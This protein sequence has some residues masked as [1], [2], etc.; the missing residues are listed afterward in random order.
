MPKYYSQ[1]GEDALLDQIFGNQEQ[2]IFIE[3]GCID[4]RRFSNTLTFEERG[5]KGI[6]VEA[7]SG[8][9]DMLKKNRPNSIVC[10][11][12][13][14]ESDE[15]TVFYANA[16]GSLSTLDKTRESLWQR[17]YAPYFAG[18]EEQQVKKVRLS[19]LLDA[20]QIEE[21]DILSLDIEGYEVEAIKGLDLSRHRPKVIVI[22]SDSPEH[23]ARLD[24][25]ILP[26]GYIKATRLGGN[27]YYVSAP[28]FAEKLKN[29][30]FTAYITHTRHPMDGAGE[31]VKMATITTEKKSIRPKTTKILNLLDKIKSLTAFNKKP[32]KRE[33][34]QLLPTGFHGDSYLLELAGDLAAKSAVFIETGSNVGSTLV[35]VA[36]NNPGIR[37]FSCEPDNEAFAETEKNTRK[38]ANVSIFKGQSQDFIQYLNDAES[39]IFEQ[40]ALFWL[41]AHGYGFEWPLK[42]EL[43]FIAEKFKKAY[44]LIDDFKVPGRPEFKYDEYNGQVCS[45]DYIEEELGKHLY[46]LYYPSYTEKT[47]AHHPLCGWGLVVI[48][49]GNWAAPQSLEGK[50]QR[51]VP[52]RQNI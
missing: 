50:I 11:C 52:T 18:F 41:D 22:E 46:S 44:I 36:R 21:I 5:W 49:D 42:Q 27:I 6:C 32:V 48:G 38:Y 40:P 33:V 23:E 51:A 28:S 47:S 24:E 1:H 7:H 3:V 13:A 8:Y 30:A 34:S 10:H 2:G 39:W 15:D 19:T 4:G 14:G 43:R 35:F 9:I 12:A 37:C 16:R 20:H 17:D 25:Q 26:G 29:A 31:C 45:F